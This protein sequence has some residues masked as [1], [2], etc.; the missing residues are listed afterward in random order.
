MTFNLTQPIIGDLNLDG[1]PD[2]VTQV[3]SND[4][5]SL[6]RP[7]VL[8]GSPGG[9][10]RPQLELFSNLDDANVTQVVY[11]DLWEDVSRHYCIAIERKWYKLTVD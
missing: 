1:Y 8:L 2:V 11:F 6:R 3:R 4:S 10:L 5:S 9:R 7:L